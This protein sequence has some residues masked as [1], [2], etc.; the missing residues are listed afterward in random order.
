MEEGDAERKR[1]FDTTEAQD[2]KR[3]RPEEILGSLDDK[4]CTTRLLLSRLEFSKIIGKGGATIM[5]IRNTCGASVK[6]SDV[7]AETRL[8]FIFSSYFLYFPLK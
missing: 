1:A 4:K 7:D 6:G 8:V 2:P 3:M 5:H